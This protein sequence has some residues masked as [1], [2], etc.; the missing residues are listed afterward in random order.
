MKDSVD[1]V[2]V[3]DLWLRDVE[4][5]T[6]L[7]GTAPRHPRL[8]QGRVR[9]CKHVDPPCR[10][11]QRRLKI[12]LG[13][14]VMRRRHLLAVIGTAA[15]MPTWAQPAWPERPTRMILPFGP[16]SSAD[17]L[18]R[19]MAEPLGRRLGQTVVCENRT[20]AGGSIG[21]AEGARQLPDGYNILMGSIGTQ[22]VNR[23]LYA[24]LPYDSDRDFT[25]IS[26]L[27]NSANVM[28]VPAG[29][30]WHSV[31]DVIAAGRQRGRLTFGSPGVGTS[32]FLASS[33]F[34]IR[35]G[36]TLE[37]VPYRGGTPAVQID[38]MA[39]RLDFG[40]GNVPAYFSG[41]RGGLVRPLAVAFPHRWPTMPEVP[42][43][44]EAGVDD[45]IV[46]SWHALVAP[47]GLPL[48][49]LN[50][51]A[52]DTQAVLHNAE[53]RAKL[54]DIGSESVGASPEETARFITSEAKRYGV[55]IR[56]LGIRAE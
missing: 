32:D 45:L 2:L 15:A 18:G 49:I 31:R 17:V 51:L 21:A 26:H 23:H 33:L 7:A 19:L 12:R 16:G 50:R 44:Q 4:S 39:G 28:V 9:E 10:R 5:C 35:T 34:G 27:W 55:L 42:T 43:M 20:G 24:H 38:L 37:H 3:T 56:R 30:P 11:R 13:G 8:N 6:N 1:Q 22:S 14:R 53:F 29:S 48:P 46:P 47:R 54:L 36:L 41:I 25:P 52:A 40:F